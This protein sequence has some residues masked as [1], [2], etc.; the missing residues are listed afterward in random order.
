VPLGHAVDTVA[1]ASVVGD[2]DDAERFARALVMVAE[3]FAGADVETAEVFI[4]ALDRVAL[5][6]REVLAGG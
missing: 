5:R 1:A 3:A 6:R 2:Q 4:A